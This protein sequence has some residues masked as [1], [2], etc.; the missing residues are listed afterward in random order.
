MFFQKRQDFVA[1]HTFGALGES[2]TKLLPREFHIESILIRLNIVTS[3]AIATA[4]ADGLLGFMKRVIITGSDGART[5]TLVDCSGRALLELAV[6]EMGTTTRGTAAAKDQTGAATYAITY[7]VNFVPP[8]LSDPVGSTFLIPAPAFTQDISVNVQ[9]ASQADL[10]AHAT[11]TAA[12]TSVTMDIIVNRRQVNALDWPTVD[13]ELIESEQAYPTTG[14]NLTYDLPSPGLFLGIL[15]RCY[16]SATARGD[17]SNGEF[18]L[19]LMQNVIRRFRLI[20][21]QDEN[22]M[23]VYPQAATGAGSFFTG[24]YYLDF[25]TDKAG[26]DASELGSGLDTNAL[27]GIGSKAQLVIDV[28]GGTNVKMKVLHRKAIGNLSQLK[29]ISKLMKSA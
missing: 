21:L 15:L 5:R 23:S 7:P 11:P 13:H 29:G 9:L 27:A 19:V 25:M 6:Q 12:I 26:Q 3:G 2:I 16:T 14:S 24:G 1:R 28:T 4:T 17:I 10:D 20:D 18:R 22:D 8:Q